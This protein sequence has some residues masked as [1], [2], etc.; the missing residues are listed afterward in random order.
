[1][2]IKSSPEVELLYIRETLQGSYKVW[3]TPEARSDHAE[4]AKLRER[5]KRSDV[6]DEIVVHVQ[7]SKIGCTRAKGRWYAREAT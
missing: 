4:L 7:R 6:L 1:M 3:R 2:Q 5:P